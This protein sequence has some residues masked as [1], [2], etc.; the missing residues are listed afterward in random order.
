VRRL[1]DGELVIASDGQGA[2]CECRAVVARRA[3]GEEASSSFRLEPA[4][5]VRHEPA[6]QPPVE[7]AFS[8]VKGD[9]TEWAVAKLTELGADRILLLVCERTVVRPAGDEPSPRRGERLRR[10]SREAAMQAR[11]VHLPTVADP[12][13]LEELLQALDPERTSL[14]EP[15]GETAGLARPVVLV[16]PEGGW[17]AGELRLATERGL[18]TVSLGAHVMRTETAAVA[19][20]ALL[21]AVRSGS[22]RPA[23]PP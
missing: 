7:I 3:R 16:G 8:L 20:A 2:W 5:P 10:I 9:R 18:S 11:R 4:G 19:A 12:V 21:T 22:V 1:R 23:A 6:P 17:S 14:A 15:G 13:A